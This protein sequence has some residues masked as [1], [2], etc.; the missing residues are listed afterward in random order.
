MN[1]KL[2]LVTVL[3]FALIAS[4]ED[5]NELELEP[6]NSG[7]ADFSSYVAVGN[8]LTAGVQSASLYQSGQ[9]F[10]F[11]NL[12]ARQLRLEDFSQP[13]IGD[14]GIG[15][16]GRIELTDLDPVT[17]TI[18]QNQGQPLNQEEKPFDNLGVPGAVLV[19][20][21]NPGN[22]GGLKERATD[23]NNPAFNPFYQIVME[24]SELEKPAPNLHNQVIKQNPTLIT[25]WLGNNDVLGY[26]LDGGEG[27]EITDPG[28]FNLLYGAAGQALLSTGA[29]VVVYTIP[30]VTT[31]PFVFALRGQLEQQGAITFNDQTQTYQLVTPQGNLDIYIE[32]DDGPRVMRQFDFPLFDATPYL[33]QVQAGTA[34]PP[35]QPGTAIA[36]EFV[37]DGPAG[38][39]QGS[40]ELEQAAGAVVQYN[41]AISTDASAF[42]F[43]VVDINQIFSTIVANFQSTGGGYTTDGLTLS[44]VPGEIFS[45]DAVHT[46]N[47]GSAIIA[48]ETIKAMNNAFGSNVPLID[49]SKIP[50]GL[51]VSS[52]G[53]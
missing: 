25:F 37:L 47:R 45:F 32:T 20:Y 21:T 31:I 15:E 27:R 51:P 8:S 14:P 44:P 50:E 24:A 34:P 3:L 30:D 41:N 46:S 13:L 53:S 6:L 22:S 36:D 16:P 43:T 4:C 29:S 10:S 33:Q 19:D 7:S 2:V 40:S 11:P 12:I 52:S 42:G 9:E 35:V 49:V 28:N 39:P 18:N 5:Y 38:G 1:K 23:P 48:N 17:F 26:V